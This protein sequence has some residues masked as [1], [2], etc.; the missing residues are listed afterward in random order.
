MEHASASERQNLAK[1]FMREN[2]FKVSLNRTQKKVFESEVEKA[3][4]RGWRGRRDVEFAK[5]HVEAKR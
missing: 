1:Y 2:E 3:S 4:Q 5:G